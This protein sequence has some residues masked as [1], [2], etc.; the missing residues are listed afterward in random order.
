MPSEE[1]ACN[2]QAAQYE[3]PESP[4]TKAQLADDKV[5]WIQQFN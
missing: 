1:I 3:Y 5:L 4:A 2:Q